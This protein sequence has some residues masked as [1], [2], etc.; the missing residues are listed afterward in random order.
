MLGFRLEANAHV[1]EDSEWVL[2]QSSNDDDFFEV[3]AAR[4]PRR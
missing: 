1:T 4:V 3:W 2:F